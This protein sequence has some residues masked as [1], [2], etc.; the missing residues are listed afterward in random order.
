MS[1]LAETLVP[2]TYVKVYDVSD[3]AN[4]VVA[5]DMSID[6]NYVGSRMAGD[7]VYVIINASVYEQD[8]EVELPVIHL[9]S[10]D[11]KV[12]ATDIYYTDIADYYYG[13]TTIAAVNVEKDNQEPKYETI[14]LGATSNLYVSLN[15]IYVTSTVW[16][17]NSEKTAIH[18]IRTSGGEIAYEASGEIPGTVLNQFS[19]DEYQGFFRVATTTTSWGGFRTGVV[20]PGVGTDTSASKIAP[21]APES[22]SANHVYILDMNLSIVSSLKDLA[23]GEQ[24]YSARFM[25]NRGY[26]VTFK[27]VDPLFVIDLTNPYAPKVLG[28]LKI[29]GYSDYLQP[30]DENHLLGIGKEAVAADEG[31][32]AWYQGV[33]ISLFD[34]SDVEN[35]KEI[36]KYEI[37]DRGTDSPVLSDHKALLFD[38]AKNLLVIPVL[39]AEIN[40]ENYPYEYGDYVWQG[41]YVFD[42]SIDGGLQLRGRITHY[43]DPSQVENYYYGANSVQRSLYIDNVLYTISEAKI[44][45]NSLEDLSYINELV[46]P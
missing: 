46:L 8:G 5:R 1:E 39:V 31:D 36:A 33:K 10:T 42:I 4:P 19:M 37:G 23:P 20:A 12:D 9:G 7:Y 43:D 29:T 44:K 32:F 6:G 28:Q 2:Q 45:M 26:I 25:G 35:P 41:A 11:V 16:S 30:Y 3:K 22:I 38:K 17:G 18:R 40:G 14:L 13:V 15:N 27:K 21:I 24:I 34:V